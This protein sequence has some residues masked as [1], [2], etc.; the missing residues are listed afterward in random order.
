MITFETSNQENEI[1]IINNINN[2]DTVILLKYC[3]GCDKNLPRTSYHKNGKTLHPTCKTCRQSE[4]KTEN[5]P[6]KEGTKYCPGCG[7]THPTSE[8]HSD[9]RSPD[10]LQ[11]YCKNY[12]DI[13][14]L[15]Y[16]CNYDNFTKN[17]FKDLKSNAKRRDIQVNI[18]I[19]DIHDLYKKQNGLCAILNIK[20]TYEAIE[21][22]TNT[23]H[24]LNK[25]NISVDRIDSSKCYTKDNIQMVCAIVNRIKTGLSNDNLLLISCAIAQNNFNKI[26][27]LVVSNIDSEYNKNIQVQEHS[28]ISDLFDK[29]QNKQII[30]IT[31]SMQKYSC[32]FDGYTNKLH[33]DIKHNLKKRAK[34]LEFS[35]T[36]NDI[37]DLYKH[38]EGKCKLSGIKMTY[39][40]YQG[41]NAHVI[42]K[43]NISVD[44]IDSSKGYIKNNI[45]LL[46]G[47]VN[48][49][50]TDLTDNEL[51]LLCNDIAK[52]K[53]NEINNLIS[54][55]LIC[56]WKN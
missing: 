22:G 34:D 39:I 12:K 16:L 43:W 5:N 50:K 17:N 56:L 41:N 54:Q 47:I 11:N 14:R 38:Q 3:K 36:V 27:N 15:K 30:N 51:L 20:M 37:R 32:S 35:I 42:N 18:T 29:M 10:G 8:F 1:S 33:L 31:T 40:G 44:R 9:K 19:Q 46:C 49:M 13:L 6:R 48:K 7:S 23:Q 28:I 26:N 2:Q 24:I 53:V 21:R 4:R 52:T 45:Q 55:N 25:W